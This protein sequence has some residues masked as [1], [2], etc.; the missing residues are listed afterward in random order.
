MEKSDKN[1]S[2]T[3]NETIWIKSEIDDPEISNETNSIGRVFNESFKVIPNDKNFAEE[4]FIKVE[5]EDEMEATRS[6]PKSEEDVEF[7]SQEY[8]ISKHTSG[9]N[10]WFNCSHCEYSCSAKSDMVKH[11]RMMHTLD[12]SMQPLKCSHCQY[13]CRDKAVM[14]KHEKMKH[15]LDKSDWFNCSYC[16]Y[17]CSDKA[18]MIKHERKNHGILDKSHWFNCS[19]CEYRCEHKGNMVRHERM[20][21]SAYFK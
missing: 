4:I 9:K 10:K 15:T 5:H 8:E 13:C 6:Y 12:K 2:S 11:E 17:S 21:H 19:Y 20:R 7:S 18:D 1:A 16:K 3:S 14:V